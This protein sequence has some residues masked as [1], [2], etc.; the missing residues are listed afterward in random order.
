M[1][2]YATTGGIPH[3]IRPGLTRAKALQT[4]SRFPRETRRRYAAPKL[5][6]F[7]LE[8]P[9]LVLALPV[10][11]MLLERPISIKELNH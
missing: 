4:V 2:C 11:K 8:Y 7:A 6:A 3:F 10:K 5:N 1:F 9:F